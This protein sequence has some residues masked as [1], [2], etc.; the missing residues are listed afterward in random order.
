[1]AVSWLTLYRAALLCTVPV[2]LF[3]LYRATS[4]RETRGAR[5]L[6]LLVCGG[7]LY[8]AVK[9][10]VSAVRGTPAVFTVTRLNP[11]AAGLAT[12]GFL[13]LAIE[14][15]GVEHPVSR[16]TVGLL[17][18]EPVAVT[19]LVWTDI[20]YLWVPAGRDPGTLSGYAW[21]VTGVAVAN[22]LY[23]NALLVLGVVL[24]GRFAV[25]SAT[26]FR[27]QAVAL[28]L[29]A[30][31]PVVGNLAFYA[32]AVPFN[33]TPVAFVFSAL[34]V[35]WAILRTGFL[36]I[37]PVGRDA[38]VSNL[39]AGVMTVD[40]DHRVIDINE[41]GYR[42]LGFD[43]ADSP[44]GRHVDAVFAERPGFREQYRSVTD[45]G[46]GQASVVEADGQYCTLE[47]TP[48]ER[49]SGEPLGH[50]VVIRDVTDRALREQE[51]KQK[52]EQLEQFAG[53]VSHDLR[54]PL[55]VILTR[56]ELIDNGGDPQ[57]HLTPIERSATRMQDMI[58]DLLIL[59]RADEHIDDLEPVSLSTTV[60][61]G[62]SNVQLGET[63]LDHRVPEDVTI[64]ADRDRLMNVFENLFRNASEHNEPAPTVRVGVLERTTANGDGALTGFFVEDDGSGIPVAERDEVFDHGYSTTRDGTGFGL[65]IVK[66]VV[67]AHGWSLSVCD[68]DDDGAR[69]EITGVERSSRPNDSHPTQPNGSR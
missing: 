53:M 38:V 15:T 34:L 9:L 48:L 26:V 51:L 11:L 45:G 10:A 67:R 32:G 24:L 17:A 14:Y 12:A 52:N 58:R 2:G 64:N 49:P 56:A 35:A 41:S 62:W 39:D 16:R 18:A 7:L 4:H 30:V 46:D 47:T 20:A 50:T 57:E 22:Q 69:F 33:P 68:G 3:V 59:A 28:L 31:G 61:D 43:D 37:V 65:A 13:L 23:M 5:P 63:E 29:A 44:V 42:L 36:D 55:E 40:S 8:V 1:M 60:Q 54:N 21:E 6:A 25:R 19:A 27:L 66:E